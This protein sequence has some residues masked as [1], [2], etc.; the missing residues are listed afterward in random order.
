[1][2][3]LRRLAFFAAT[4]SSSLYPCRKKSATGSPATSD[5]SLPPYPPSMRAWFTST[6]FM[7]ERWKPSNWVFSASMRSLT[8]KGPSSV[9]YHP[10]DPVPEMAPRPERPGRT[11]ERMH[12]FTMF[13]A[14]S[15]P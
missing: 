14:S 10:T 4:F 1:L 13:P 8:V 12:L 7:V 3:G 5:T 2:T 15:M 11:D 9:S 6:R